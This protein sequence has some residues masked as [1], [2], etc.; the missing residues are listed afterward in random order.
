M[1]TKCASEAAT[2]VLGALLAIAP[3]VTLAEQCGSKL[4]SLAHMLKPQDKDAVARELTSFHESADVY[5]LAFS[6]DSQTL[7]TA[8]ALRKEVRLWDWKT[9]QMTRELPEAPSP[10]GA[11]IMFAVESIS[12]SPRGD[13]VASCHVGYNQSPAGFVISTVWSASTGSLVK[14]LVQEST[15]T[16]VS[17]LPYGSRLLESTDYGTSPERASL[18]DTST[19]QLLWTWSLQKASPQATA[20]SPDGRFA[21]I[22]TNDSEPV[23]NRIPNGPTN[24]GVS[25]VHIIDLESGREMKVLDTF[26]G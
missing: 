17:F 20:I 10:Q 24:H 1:D 3:S 5:G 7:A 11:A 21:A 26:A 15:C 14:E 2:L 25:R 12:F 16:G 22:G 8:M 18:Y 19:W 6:P 13:E 9:G 4:G 23:L